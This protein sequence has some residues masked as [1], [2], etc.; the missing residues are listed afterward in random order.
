MIIVDVDDTDFVLRRIRRDWIRKDG[1]PTSQN[2]TETPDQWDLC[3]N[4][5][6]CYL[7]RLAD[8]KAIVGDASLYRLARLSVGEIRRRR[9]GDVVHYP[10]KETGEY[11]HAL[12]I[13]T[14]ETSIGKNRR[15]KELANLAELTD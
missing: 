7:E 13:R 14:K 15:A 1:R 9:L 5:I 3:N 11:S 10:D 12:I 6:S 4:E 2:F 8:P